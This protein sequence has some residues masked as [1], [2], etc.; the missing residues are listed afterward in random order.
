M[1]EQQEYRNKG[2][3]EIFS[4]IG[5]MVLD[6]QKRYKI[7]TN[8]VYCDIECVL[9]D[10]E[11]SEEYFILD[12]CG[13]WEY[14]PTKCY[15]V[16][17]SRPHPPAPELKHGYCIHYRVC[18]SSIGEPCKDTKCPEYFSGDWSR[19]HNIF[20]AKQERERVLPFLDELVSPSVSDARKREIVES[21]RQQE[22]RP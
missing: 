9:Q 12:E 22:E 10:P 11:N 18:G 7:L 2:T 1:T 3:N 8:L 16:V 6:A 5:E 15:E 20:V 21:L 14:F 13:N 19:E 4:D 17:H